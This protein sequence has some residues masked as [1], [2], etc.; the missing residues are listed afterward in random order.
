V[1]S[2]YKNRTVI[3]QRG[4]S[5][6]IDNS[7][8]KEKIQISHRSGSNLNFTNIVTSELASN[9]KQLIVI[10]DNFKTVGGTESEYTV[11]DKI[12]RV[13]ENSY[14]F[15]GT[16]GDSEIESFKSWKNAYKTIANANSVFKI[17][18][19]GSSFPNGPTTP[20]TGTRASNPTLNQTIV[21]VENNFNGYVKT[22]IRTSSVDE[23][24]AYVPI[25]NR[26]TNPATPKN[27]TTS[28]ID[29]AAGGSGSSAPGV[30]EFGSSKSAATEGGTWTPNSQSEN[31][32][33]SIKK[34][35][36]D[37]LNNIE[38]TMGNGGDDI[39]FVKRNKSDTVGAIFND[40]PSIRIDTKGRSQPIEIVVSASGA[41]KNHDYI[42]IVEDIDNSST[43]PCGNENKTVGNKYNLNVGSGGINLKTT[44]SIELG[45]SNLKM[46]FQKANISAT[47]GIHLH[48]ESVVELVSLKS[49]SLRTNRQVYIESSLGVKNNTIIGGGLY[50]EGE[51]YLHHITAPIEIQ[52]TLDTTLYGRFNCV[53]PRTLPIGEVFDPEWG[54][55]TVYALANDNLIV[56][57]PHSHHFPNLPLRLTNSNS[58][59]RKFASNERINTHGAISTALAQKHERRTAETAI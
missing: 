33:E 16:Y 58:D 46:G 26:S 2:R 32:G 42:P 6:D 10:N 4:G 39:S 28:D 56:N 50:T 43:F 45:G 17:N 13:G 19:G 41:F 49:I 1:S 24:V 31:L 29:R 34:V 15:K 44:G 11:K 12:E 21:P 18:R 22:P 3:N 40:Y 54:W 57:Y 59:V 38:S 36:E 23:V 20:T 35:Q 25:P 55:L 51:V 5:I 8:E 53:A 48:S 27:V 9:N 52:Q 14:S 7:T 30:L 47:H 37:I